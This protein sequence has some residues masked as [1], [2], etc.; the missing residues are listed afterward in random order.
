GTT[1]ITGISTIP[2]LTGTSVNAAQNLLLDLAGSVSNTT[3]A[4]NVLRPGDTTFV[5]QVRVKNYH[6]NEWGG[7]FK[8]DWKI[9][10]DLTLNLGVRYD[11]YGVPWEA[12]GMQ[13]LPTGGNAGL[14][15]ITAG[16]PTVLQLVGKNSNNP[17]TLLYQNDN[18]NF[19]P[20]I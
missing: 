8:D 19:A 20:A 7:F 14:Y 16:A 5:P 1:A 11:W 18:N 10:P 12:N 13:A 6:Q 9:R 17:N 15:G 4:F 3:L 2:G